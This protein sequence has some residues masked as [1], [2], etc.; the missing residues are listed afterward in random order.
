MKIL[1]QRDVDEAAMLVAHYIRTAIRM[2]DAQSHQKCVRFYGVPRGGIPAA[3]LVARHLTDFVVDMVDDPANADWFIDDV[4][5]SGK[6]RNRYREKHSKGRFIS[7]YQTELKDDKE[8]DWLSF[9]WERGENSDE[10]ATDIPTRLLQYIGEDVNREGLK[11][12]PQR[13]LKAW[14]H[15][16]KGYKED[17]KEIL[18]AF[19]DGAELCDDEIILVANLPVW[20]MCEHHL[21]PFFGIAHI[22]YIPNEKIVGL[23]KFQR[24]VDVFGRR[25]QVQERLTNQIANAMVDHLNPEAVGVVLECRHLCMEARGVAAR[26][27]VTVTS[28][29][30]GAF[31]T[32]DSARAEFMSLVRGASRGMPI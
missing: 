15:Y 3:Y 18:K 4:I 1:T 13:F 30:R 20:S 21:A 10:S 23:S 6:T 29:L 9:P 14:Q 27:A 16:T 5:A 22:G 17:P 28:A 32:E 7:L 19:T 24:L 26:G 8:T 25:L 11:E 31:K 12:T 2:S